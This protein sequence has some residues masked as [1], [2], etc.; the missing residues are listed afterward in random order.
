MRSS[1]V[2]W[3]VFTALIFTLAVAPAG[4]ALEQMEG[5]PVE[6]LFPG[7]TF[8]AS[9]P[10]QHEIF[11][12]HPGARPLRHD[13]VMRYLRALADASPRATI[14]EYSRSHEGRELVYFA[15]SDEATIRDLESFKASHVKAVD[16][17]TSEAAAVGDG[18]AVAWIAYGI[19]GDEL[20]S[21]DAAVT[22][23]Y[24]LV[25]G[26]DDLSNKLRKELLILIDPMENP[27][28]RDR[29]LAQT[30]SFAHKV[31][32]ADTDDLSHTTVW[33]W[34]RGN[35]YLF[36]LNRDWFSMVQPES[37]RAEV[38]A[39][40]HP[41]LVVDSHEMG[42]HDTY[43]FS[44]PRH[45]FNPYL[46]PTNLDWADRFAADQA[47]AL[48]QY[49]YPYY[50]RE[51][52]EEFFPGYGS[53]WSSYL[54]AVGIL[55]EMSGTEGTLVKTRD[56][57]LRTYPQAI[58]HQAT[59]S[60]ANLTTLADNRTE[61]LT[62]YVQD[63][64]TAMARAGREWPAAW[65][66]PRGR[67]PERT[68]HLVDLLQR[69]SIEVMQ[70]D[71]G[72]S[73]LS[74]LIDSR[75]G[76]SVKAADL[77]ADVYVVPLD[78]PAG[79][80]VRQLLDPHIPME[81]G[82]LREEREYIERG[83]GSRLYEVT[84]WSL[85]LAYDVEAYWTKTKPAGEWVAAQVPEA[86]GKVES[87]ADAFGFVID[88]ISDRT[89]PLLVDL[90]QRGIRPHVAEKPFKVDGH[91]YPT[92]TLLIIGEGNPDDLEAQLG[93]V[94]SSH[95]VTIR[96]IPTAK[97][98]NGPD[99]GSRRYK[100]L[101]APKL[102]VL[103]GWPVSPTSYGALWHMLDQDL[104]LRFNALDLGRFGSHDLS[105]YNVLIF[106]PAGRGAG[107]YRSVIGKPGVEQLT[108]WIEAGGT[109]I[110]VGSGAEFLADVDTEL[111]QTRLRRQA[112]EKFPP[113]V[114]GPS[115]AKVEQG[116][117]FRAVGL[118]AG[119]ESTEDA[120][121]EAAS[122]YDVAPILG[123]GAKPF[124]EG[125]DQGTAA[126]IKPVDLADWVKPFLSPGQSKAEKEDLER[127]DRRLRQFSPRGVFLKVE[128][129][130]NVWLAWG[131]PSSLPALVRSNDTLVA[132]S[133]VQVAARFAD[134]EQLQLGGLLWPEAAG[135][136]ANTAYATREGK[137]R[138]QVILF[139][140]EPEFRGWT[141]G[142]RRMLVNAI[143]YG[144]GLGTRW[145][146]PW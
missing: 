94:A 28:G 114:L 140:N 39:S 27:D 81:S 137:G 141:L 53:S 117:S 102:G 50:T 101:I 138:G 47:R 82:F 1:R 116:G 104:G 41:Q 125:H 15:V 64:K 32:N 60:I 56:G 132:E 106:P 78:Q 58:H 84:A 26:T 118:R 62:D 133:P 86:H 123:P 109:A 87:T 76:Q 61:V 21:S 18:K 66:L 49:G 128:T 71:G 37:R 17:R 113:V 130:E 48:D 19:H 112:I 136:L 65:V 6:Q 98:E 111:T 143:L 8:D 90:L 36:D 119:D 43:L 134:V 99:L 5:A 10:T 44:P 93:E 96:A 42:S 29:F 105:R 91:D 89:L 110:G 55:Y 97:A 131:M 40:W 79:P 16:P 25:A 142:T 14:Q 30:S 129:D 46:P 139:L 2:R 11:G 72:K 103:A 67:H 9:I 7:A 45:P 38:I 52:N 77:P 92:S 146:N 54:G 22:V 34:G 35:H 20:S 120:P 24:R 88:G 107:S 145:S 126:A 121:A 12:F 83:K 75:T 33:P 100:Q 144:P 68:D 69:E 4:A 127:A 57:R 23:A 74:G 59:S 95:D 13:E 135:R 51:W 3:F 70:N 122:P 85:V 108:R 80:L 115:A 63:R 73:K 31:P 124:A